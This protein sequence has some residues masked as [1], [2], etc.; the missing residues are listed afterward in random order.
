MKSGRAE[1]VRASTIGW[2]RG[3]PPGFWAKSAKGIGGIRGTCDTENKRV[4]K[5]LKRWAA[6]HGVSVE[7]AR[8]IGL[9]RKPVYPPPPGGPVCA[10]IAGVNGNCAG[11]GERRRVKERVP[12][13]NMAY[14]LALFTTRQQYSV[15]LGRFFGERVTGNGQRYGKGKVKNRPPE[16]GANGAHPRKP[17]GCGTQIH[18]SASR[19]RHP[20]ED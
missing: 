12:R 10:G 2:A 4:S 1:R 15:V 20:A 14:S 13:A 9:T 11:C 5:C 19:V 6:E 17:Q 8:R 18:L 7:G 16:A 3:V